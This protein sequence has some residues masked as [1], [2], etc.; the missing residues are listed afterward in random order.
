MTAK[1][2]KIEMTKEEI[3]DD[4]SNAAPVVNQ[5]KLAEL[6]AK[7]AAKAKDAEKPKADRALKLG[8]IGLGQGG[9]SV[10]VEFFKL[11][12]AY[13]TIVV[14]TARQ[15]LDL[16]DI[17]D[18]QKI[19]LDTGVSGCAKDQ[20]VGKEV[21]EVYYDTIATAVKR[22]L[23]DCQAFIVCSSLGG[24][25][26]SGSL[27]V[28]IDILNAT[29]KPVLVLALLPMTSDDASIKSNSVNS[30]EALSDMLKSGSIANVICVDNAKIEEM[31][32]DVS[33][34][35]FF[36]LA[37]KAIVEPLC[38][39]NKLSAMPSKNQAFDG[40]EFTRLLLEGRGCVSYSKITMPFGE[41]E[42]PLSIAT[43]IEGSLEANLL[44]N[45]DIKNAHLAS[46]VVVASEK[47]WETIP[48][49]HINYASAQFTAKCEGAIAV[50]KGYYVDNTVED[51]VINIFSI[52][53]GLSMPHQRLDFLRVETAQM[54][55]VTKVKEAERTKALD[56]ASNQKEKHISKID[57]VKAKIAK[58]QS[59]F[60][61]FL[62]NNNTI[63]RRKK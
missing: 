15:D 30:L 22:Q 29:Q 1:S 7:L 11:P 46:L 9:S 13:P 42:N 52:F 49:T 10:A 50:F 60:G 12:N 18:T 14:N 34:M 63:D 43:A 3:H 48:S 56:Q 19:F 2:E 28:V 41:D 51:G 62:A 4:I 17:P 35:K 44:S 31:Y 38:E 57:E 27:P 5:D 21:A 39:I 58:S 32:S 26:G 45:L 54:A 47:T 25:T 33:Y 61:K 40:A 8:I 16:L 23:G 24:G 59:G 6:K 53:S 20:S 55:E 37:N 36:E